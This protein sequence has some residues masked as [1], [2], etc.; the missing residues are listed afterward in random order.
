MSTYPLAIG[1]YVS[2]YNITPGCKQW[3]QPL[4]PLN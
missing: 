4:N 3:Q 1:I 2:E